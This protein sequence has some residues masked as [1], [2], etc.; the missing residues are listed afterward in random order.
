MAGGA[1]A[2]FSRG[3][4]P[5]KLEDFVIKKMIGKGTFGKVYLVELNTKPG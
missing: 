4:F 3:K 2:L 1:R 5:A